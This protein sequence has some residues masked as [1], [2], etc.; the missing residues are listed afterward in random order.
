M[1]NRLFHTPPTPQQMARAFRRLGW[2]GFWCQ[3]ILGFIPVI[4]VFFHWFF[5]S[6]NLSAIGVPDSGNIISFIDILTLIFTIYWCFRYTRSAKK[7]EDYDQRPT[8]VSVIREV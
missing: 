7:I 5:S 2:I 6:K 4:L 3:A 1:L 8:K